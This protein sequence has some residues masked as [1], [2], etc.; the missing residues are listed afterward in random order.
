MAKSK[1]ATAEGKT[2]PSPWWKAWPDEMKAEPLTTAQMD[3]WLAGQR[4][5]RVLV[6]PFG[7]PLP[8]GKA[9]LD[10]DGDAFD[11]DTDLYGGFPALMETRERLV[12]WHHDGDPTGVMKGAV[13][14][15]IVMDEDPSEDGLWADFWANAGEKRRTLMAQLEAKGVPLYGSSQAIT[16][17]VRKST[18]AEG[19]RHIDV[20]PVIRHTITTS[21]QNTYATVPSIKAILTG[22]IEPENSLSVGAI[23]AAM[24]DMDG[25]AP[26]TPDRAGGVGNVSGNVGDLTPSQKAR[27]EAAL[28]ALAKVVLP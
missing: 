4:A 8:G 23:H 16:S 7:G 26:W 20:W 2:S 3:H 28:D 24:L 12:D 21:P 19:G 14:G 1:P 9:G 17:A 13:L 15:R 11:A 18:M 5:R 10:L 25:S 6:I 22:A 27:L